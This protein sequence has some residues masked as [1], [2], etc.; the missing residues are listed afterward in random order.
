MI[1]RYSPYDRKGIYSCSRERLSDHIL[2]YT[3]CEAICQ[4][5][6]PIQLFIE[7]SVL[8]RPT[9]RLTPKPPQN[10]LGYPGAS[11]FGGHKNKMLVPDTLV[12]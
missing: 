8:G 10:L 1:P 3:A 4:L 11:S 12:E 9:A 6:A 5:T 2:V 7:Q